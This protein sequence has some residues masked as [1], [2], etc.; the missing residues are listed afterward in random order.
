MLLEALADPPRAPLLA[1]TVMGIDGEG[2]SAV[3]IAPQL[4]A[5]AKTHGRFTYRNARHGLY[6]LPFAVR[7]N[8][9]I[10][11]PVDPAF[12]IGGDRENN[13]YAEKL[14]AAAGGVEIDAVAWARLNTQ[15]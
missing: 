2:V 7:D 10:G 15:E 14:A 3:F 11:C 6:V 13:P 5:Q 8:L 12:H 1:R 4:A 9:G